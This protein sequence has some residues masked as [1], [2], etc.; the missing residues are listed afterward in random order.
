[1]SDSNYINEEEIQIAIKNKGL[2][3]MPI[4][5]EPIESQGLT[6]Y[7][8]PSPIYVDW[9]VLYNDRWA[10]QK[11]KVSEKDGTKVYNCEDVDVEL[12]ISKNSVVMVIND[13][14]IALSVS[15]AKVLLDILKEHFDEE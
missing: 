12:H 6:P 1:M 13:G 8:S 15:A 2:N 7:I 4:G 11:F 14:V 3:R 5:T 9:G 10:I